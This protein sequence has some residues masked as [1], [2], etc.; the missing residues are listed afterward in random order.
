MCRGGWGIA[1]GLSAFSLTLPVAAADTSWIGPVGVEADWM[2]PANW[3][4]GLPDS[5][6]VAHVDN[7][8]NAV[9]SDANNL[10][11]SVYVGTS[12]GQTGTVTLTGDGHLAGYIYVG[13]GGTG[14][15]IQNG[16]SLSKPGVGSMPQVELTLGNQAGSSGTYRLSGRVFGNPNW[17]NAHYMSVGVKGTGVV[18]QTG[19]TAYLSALGVR[20]GT[21]SLSGSGYLQV[22]NLI[23]YGGTFVQ[24]GGHVQ[25]GWIGGMNSSNSVYEIRSGVLNAQQLDVGYLQN[26]GLFNISNPAGQIKA[27]NLVLGENGTLLACPGA[28]VRLGI[29]TY[30]VSSSST[31]YDNQSTNDANFPGLANVRLLCDDGLTRQ[32]AI[33]VA[34]RKLDDGQTS[35]LNFTLGTLQIGSDAAPGFVSLQDLFDNQPDWTGSECLHVKDLVITAGSRLDLNGLSIYYQTASIDPGADIRLLGGALVLIPEPASMLL[36]LVGGVAGLLARRRRVQR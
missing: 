26:V 13:N 25:A 15:L 20:K 36:L 17:N 30:A 27:T 22:A 33:E 14:T 16:G 24:N 11:K 2:S 19:G 34:G 1:I 29:D 9:I 8:G 3:D 7:G 28:T 31:S 5:N 12:A 10:S 32:S 21:Y 6:T 35:D 18:E 4:N 23:M